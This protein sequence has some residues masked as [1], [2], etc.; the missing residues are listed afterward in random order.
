MTRS[1]QQNKAYWDLSVTPIALAAGCSPMEMHRI[2]IDE[3]A[4]KM[5][6]VT[7]KKG[8]EFKRVPG[9]SSIMSTK[10]FSEYWE[11]V[12]MIGSTIYGVV[13][14]SPYVKEPEYKTIKHTV[15]I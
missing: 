2:L 10:R 14:Q 4:G 13:C 9:S 6:P 7:T 5:I 1:L 8:V 15:L 12:N 11:W 3:F